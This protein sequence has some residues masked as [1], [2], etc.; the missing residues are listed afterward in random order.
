[1]K[2]LNKNTQQ[3]QT[4]WKK[5]VFTGKASMP[6]QVNND[7]DVVALVAKTPGS[8][9]LVDKTKAKDSVKAIPAP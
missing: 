4:G 8:I 6:E 9:G 5:L 1:M 2:R 7:D 3:F